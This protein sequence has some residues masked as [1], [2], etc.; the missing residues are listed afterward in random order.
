MDALVG[1]GW[2]VEHQEDYFRDA[3]HI[4]R[5]LQLVDA[6]AHEAE[7]SIEKILTLDRVVEQEVVSFLPPSLVFAGILINTAEVAI[8]VV[9]VGRGGLVFRGG[10]LVKIGRRRRLNFFISGRGVVCIVA[11]YGGS[12]GIC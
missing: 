4:R 5:G 9:V 6:L 7:M 10:L 3:V 12:A 8:V 1:S 11:Q 2:G